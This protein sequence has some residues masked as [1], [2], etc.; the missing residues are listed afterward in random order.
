MKANHRL[1]I[2]YSR[3]KTNKK[4]GQHQWTFGVYNVY[5]QINPYATFLEY[6]P[7]ATDKP[8]FDLQGEYFTE[9]PV[10]FVTYGFKF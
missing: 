10:P 7:R 4:G 6:N 1:D 8:I 2:S 9:W 3:Q 5:G